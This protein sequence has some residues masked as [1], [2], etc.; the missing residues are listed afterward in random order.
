MPLEQFLKTFHAVITGLV[1][2]E[3]RLMQF[4]ASNFEFFT[5]YGAFL[6]ATFSNY[7]CLSSVFPLE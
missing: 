7:V 1:F 4:F 2:F 6:L 5:K 3:Q